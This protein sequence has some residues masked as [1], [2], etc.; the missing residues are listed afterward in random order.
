M[1]AHDGNAIGGRLF[2]YFGGEMTM[3]PGTCAHCGAKSLIAELRVYLK[4]PGTV[5]RCPRC[6]NVVIVLVGVRDA[7]R[8]DFSAFHL[9]DK[10]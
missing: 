8:V 10:A 7:M 3:A 1:D 2:D 6:G 9:S 5:A 4:A